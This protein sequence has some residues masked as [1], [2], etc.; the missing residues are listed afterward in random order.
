[1]TGQERKIRLSDLPASVTFEGLWTLGYRYVDGRKT[2]VRVSLDEIQ[3]AYTDVK[4]ATREAVAMTDAA[5][6]AVERAIT[7]AGTAERINEAVSGAEIERQSRETAREANERTRATAESE[8]AKAETA[9]QTAEESRSKAEILRS[10]DEARRVE[11]ETARNEAERKRETETAAAIQA[12]GEAT[13][14]ADKA[15]KRANTA[16][17]AAEGVVSGVRPDWLAPEGSPNYIANKPEIPT[18]DTPPATDTLGYV[19]DAGVTVPFRI[20]DEARVREDDGFVFYRLYDLL[21]GVAVWEESGAG[22]SLP[23]NVYLQGATYYNDSVTVIKQGY[24][25]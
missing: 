18:M 19:K 4:A 21:D 2:S 15:A 23:G 17:E 12:A 16:A 1:M 25:E 14:E 22:A 7:A 8:R 24:Y 6:R 3:R 10:D 20:G 13:G 11:S 5:G 9:R